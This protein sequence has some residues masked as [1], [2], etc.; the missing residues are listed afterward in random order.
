[1]NPN[2]I[3]TP[4]SMKLIG[5]SKTYR[6]DEIYDVVILGTGSKRMHFAATFLVESLYREHSRRL[7]QTRKF[8]KRISPRIFSPY[9]AEQDG[10]LSGP[11]AGL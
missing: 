5:G 9:H 2:L 11:L 10:D 6:V 1:M 4:Q 3:P 7:C 8:F